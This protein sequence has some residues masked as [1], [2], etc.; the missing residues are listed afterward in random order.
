LRAANFIADVVTSADEDE[1]VSGWE[2]GLHHVQLEQKLRNSKLA[3]DCKKCDGYRCQICGFHFGERYGPLG[4]HFAEAHHIV[5]PSRKARSVPLDELIT[6]C[7]NCH[8]ML[9]KMRPA[10]DVEKLKAVY[11]GQSSTKIL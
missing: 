9:H 5:P 10:P 11:E 3:Q 1:D 7:A 4:L 8:R 6:V 2:G